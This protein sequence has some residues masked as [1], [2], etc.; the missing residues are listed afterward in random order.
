M[1]PREYKELT[2]AEHGAMV[3]VM[4]EESREQKRRMAKMERRR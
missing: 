3:D 2:V 4:K 1:T